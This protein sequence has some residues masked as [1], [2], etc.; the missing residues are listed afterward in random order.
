MAGGKGGEGEEEEE[1]GGGDGRCERGVVVAVVEEERR[2][3]DLEEEVAAAEA[4]RLVDLD[5]VELFCPIV[6]CRCR[7][8]VSYVVLFVELE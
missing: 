8:V 6:L 7:Y 1:E 5:W 3:L 2:F 4:W